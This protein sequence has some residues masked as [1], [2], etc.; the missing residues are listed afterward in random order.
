MVQVVF[1][2]METSTLA[3]NVIQERVSHIVKKFPTLADHKITM[4]LEM[5]NSPKQAGPD[6][7]SANVLVTGKTFKAIRLKKTSENFYHAIAVLMD[8]FVYTISKK[9]D[10]RS[11]LANKKKQKVGGAVA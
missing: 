10:R 8:R 9:S 11:S 7:Y 2:N 4:T 5:Y 3:K 6:M 1:K